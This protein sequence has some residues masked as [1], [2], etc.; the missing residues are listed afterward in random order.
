MTPLA[1]VIMVWLIII[2]AL[3]MDKYFTQRGE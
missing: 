3:V 2:A 1:W